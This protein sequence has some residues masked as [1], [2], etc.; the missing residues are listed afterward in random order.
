MYL[1]LEEDD[2]EAIAELIAE[3]ENGYGVCVSYSDLD[4]QVSFDM[5]VK[6]H[7]DTDYYNGTGAWITD[8]VDFALNDVICEGVEIKYSHSQLQR[9]IIERLWEV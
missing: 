7:Q 3:S 1:R 4:I 6:S 9:T 2:Y 8:S 5:D